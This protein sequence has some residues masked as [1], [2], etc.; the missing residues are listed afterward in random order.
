MK[1]AD[2]VALYAAHGIDLEHVA[3]VASNTDGVARKRRMGK[4]ERK[5][6]K[7]RPIVET[8]DGTSDRII[9]PRAW[10]HAELGI[11]AGGLVIGAS[12]DP[13]RNADGEYE[14]RLPRMPWLAICYHAAGDRSG[15]K[16]LHRG[17]T[18]EAIHLASRHN[19]SWQIERTNGEKDYYLERLTELVLDDDGCHP[20]FLEPVT[21]SAGIA[22]FTVSIRR[23]AIYMGVTDEVWSKPLY[24]HFESIKAH[25]QGWLATA[26]G[27]IGQW[28]QRE[29]LSDSRKSAIVAAESPNAA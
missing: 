26:K 27:V 23:Y 12:G 29:D 18:L 25:Y 10:S 21:D 16:E 7:G 19:W 15:Y 20:A 24:G 14:A 28:M 11:C 8:A 6:A 9:R 4:E 3:G 13:I 17:L 1:P 2:L 22:H 5:Q